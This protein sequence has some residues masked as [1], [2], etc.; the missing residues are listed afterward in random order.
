[1]LLYSDDKSK[2]RGS[3]NLHVKPRLDRYMSKW[4]RIFMSMC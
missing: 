1:M 3:Q 2:Q 4:N